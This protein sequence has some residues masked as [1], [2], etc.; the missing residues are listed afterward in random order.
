MAVTDGARRQ[1][2]ADMLYDHDDL[3]AEWSVRFVEEDAPHPVEPCNC[4]HMVHN[5]IGNGEHA[6]FAV[7]AGTHSVVFIGRV[8]DHCA[9]THMAPLLTRSSE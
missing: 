6:M 9:A 8:C 1:V 5:A 3:G 7:P 2:L 4:E